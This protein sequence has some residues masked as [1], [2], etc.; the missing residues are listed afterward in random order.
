[1]RPERGMRTMPPAEVDSILSAH[2]LYLETDRKQGARANL[3]SVDL[4]GNGSGS[5]VTRISAAEKRFRSPQ[6]D[7]S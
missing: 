3:S 5:T 6:P 2:R 1:L 4:P 7:R